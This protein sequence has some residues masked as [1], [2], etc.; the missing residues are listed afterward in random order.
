M[1]TITVSQ[2]YNATNKSNLLTPELL[3]YYNAVLTKPDI[4]ILRELFDS[5]PTQHKVLAA[6][7][8]TS[9]NSL[10]NRFVRLE[11]IEPPLIIAERI[12][13]MKYYSLSEIAQAFMEQQF[14]PRSDRIRVF[15]AVPQDD[16]LLHDT[17]KILERFQQVAGTEWDVIMDDLL[18]GKPSLDEKDEKSSEIKIL[19]EDFIANIKE[20]HILGKTACIQNIYNALDENILI[21]RLKTLIR[22][23]LNGYHALEPL[24]KLEQQSYEKAFSLI[25]YV[26][27]RINSAIFPPV[28]STESINNL[29]LSD[30]QLKN[31]VYAILEML[32]EFRTFNGNTALAVNHWK[33]VYSS[34]SAALYRIADK[35]YTIYYSETKQ[36]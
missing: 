18:S 25:D 8:H 34:A 11:N 35:C 32:N 31:V 21:C 29:M 28:D 20:F 36:K 4:D 33:D 23:E 19:Y 26:F 12:G 14:P 30:D 24:F 22:S 10:S 17:L 27:S 9:T 2:E 15:T 13:R 7:L 5:P 1:N 6:N 3:R 16:N